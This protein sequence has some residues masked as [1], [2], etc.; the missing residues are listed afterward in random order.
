MLYRIVAI[1]NTFVDMQKL[2]EQFQSCKAAKYTV[3]T[4][5]LINYRSIL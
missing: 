2:E 4:K 5:L 1:D 3:I